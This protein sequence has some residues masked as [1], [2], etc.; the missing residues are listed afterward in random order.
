MKNQNISRGFLI[1]C[2]ILM[3]GCAFTSQVATLNP[4]VPNQ[5]YNLGFG[6]TIGLKVLD[7]RPNK[8]LGHRGSAYGP[9]AEI[10]T[11]QNVGS[12]IYQKIAEGLRKNGFLVVPQSDGIPAYLKVE[13]RQIKYHSAAGLVTFTVQSNSAI[14]GI[15]KNGNKSYEQMYR[16]EYEEEWLVVPFAGTNEEIINKSLSTVLQNMFLDKRL[17]EC[18]SHG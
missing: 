7:E 14:K 13:I 2:L 1:T 6:K 11:G 3:N 12:L 15:C 18:L 4:Q 5:T 10:S 17:L 8:E 16:G 9:S